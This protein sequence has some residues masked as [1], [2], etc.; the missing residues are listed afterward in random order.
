M[1]RTKWLEDIQ[2]LVGDDVLRLVDP[3]NGWP[4]RATIK[5]SG[6]DHEVLLHV[7]PI[8][9]SQRGRDAVERRFQNPGNNRPLKRSFP[10]HSLLLG[11]WNH[12]KSETV[13]RPVLVAMQV[14]PERCQNP[15]RQSYFIPLS[16]LRLA[17]KTGWAEHT[18]ESGETITAF[19]PEALPAFVELDIASAKVDAEFIKTFIQAAGYFQDPEDPQSRVRVRRQLLTLARSGVF[20]RNVTKAYNGRCSMCGLNASL[21]EAAHIYPVAALDSP[22]EIWNGLC[23]CRNHHAAFDRNLITVTPED[24]RIE[25]GSRL[26]DEAKASVAGSALCNTFEKLQMP[27]CR[28]HYP[29]R[30]MLTKRYEF[31]S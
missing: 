27:A 12:D 11:I 19:V 17:S 26:L 7:G 8:G 3:G 18:S 6:R 14:T 10:E 25:I 24:F 22:D 16:V 15:T 28:E 29:S 21:V 31:F 2:A 9:S 5:G 1:R 4:G 13:S 20:S 23:L 30:E